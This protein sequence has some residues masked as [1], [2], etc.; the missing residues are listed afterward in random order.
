MSVRQEVLEKMIEEI[1]GPY[2]FV[3]DLK[4]TLTI[5]ISNGDV[6]RMVSISPQNDEGQ[7]GI[8]LVLSGTPEEH[9]EKTADN[10]LLDAVLEVVQGWAIET[11]QGEE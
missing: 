2:I 5:T 1:F 10:N 11:L 3:S 6:V 9:I 4:K 7:T 8:A